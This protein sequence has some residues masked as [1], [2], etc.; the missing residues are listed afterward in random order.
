MFQFF[1]LI[2]ETAGV[3]VIFAAQ[4]IFFINAKEKY[5]SIKRAFLTIGSST[6]ISP[7]PEEIYK[8]SGKQ[9][10]ENLKKF[11]HA[12][13][14]YNDF[15]WSIIGLFVSLLGNSIQMLAIYFSL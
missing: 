4:F 8:M 13:L 14:F 7:G 11:L 12:T 1:G 2:I 6:Q 9:V 10:D 3:F 5:G 15:K